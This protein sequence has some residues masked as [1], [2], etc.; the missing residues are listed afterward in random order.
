MAE[1][2]PSPDVARAFNESLDPSARREFER[3]LGRVLTEGAEDVEPPEA[4]AP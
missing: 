4:K 3:F 1:D 2:E